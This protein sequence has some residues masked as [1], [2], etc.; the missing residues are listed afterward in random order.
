M[1]KILLVIN[2]LGKAGAEKALIEM[3]KSID[4]S[5]YEMSLYVILGQGEMIK[6]IPPYVK[7]LNKEYSPVSVLDREG[8]KILK[9]NIFKRLFRNKSIFKNFFY[10]VSIT[11]SM[12]FKGKINADKLLW[13]TMSDGGEFFDEEY[14]LAVAYLEGGATYYVKDHV[15][16]KKKAAFV[17]IDY[18]MAG[19]TRKI[20]RNAY[21]FFDR[22][23]TVSS[24]VRDSF[25]KVYGECSDKTEVFDNIINGS[26][27]I[28][29]SL[30][31]NG[32]EDGFDGK[33][34][35]T[36]GRLTTQKAFE[37]SI[38]TLSI[39]KEKGCN[40]RWYVLGEGDQRKK[41]EDLIEKKNLKDDFILFGAVD[42]PYPYMKQCDL[43]VH[44][45]RFEGKSIA[46]R[47]AQVLG[48]PII[49]SDCNGNRE[50]VEN[51]KDG[52]ISKLDSA[53]LAGTIEILLNDEKLG[54]QLG[55][56][57][58]QKNNGENDLKKLLGLIG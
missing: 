39:L 1:K 11:L 34:I 48:K 45:S 6:E 51:K 31:G 27:I 49:V 29:K 25:L 7:I 22:I 36:V 38:E 42:N 4:P 13:K 47:E 16:A 43:Y 32:F 9:K 5:E 24:E 19:Y 44:A 3:I 23:F 33:R 12:V 8:K 17:H 52:L 10:L 26:E 56:M 55:A 37:I 53:E 2:T 57:A 20:D 18:G 58:A 40:V 54:R 35:L 46:V 30:L 50:Q 28:E 14:D 15:N 41:L 21:L